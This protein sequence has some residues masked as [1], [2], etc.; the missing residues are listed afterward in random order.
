MNESVVAAR[1]QMT[2]AESVEQANERMLASMRKVGAEQQ[3]YARAASDGV[4]RLAQQQRAAAASADRLAATNQRVA[5]SFAGMLAT[6]TGVGG[7]FL[8]LAQ[9]AEQ[10]QPALEALEAKFT[11]VNSVGTRFTS[12]AG[13]MAAAMQHLPN[14][15]MGMAVGAAVGQGIAALADSMNKLNGEVERLRELDAKGKQISYQKR[16]ESAGFMGP[17]N[18]I[19]NALGDWEEVDNTGTGVTTGMDRMLAKLAEWGDTAATVSEAEKK[20]NAILVQNKAVV[21]TYTTSIDQHERSL[22]QRTR[23]VLESVDAMSKDGEAT[24]M[25]KERIA[26]LLPVLQ[27]LAKEHGENIPEG[28]AN[29]IAKTTAAAK[30]VGLLESEFETVGK[31]AKKHKASIEAFVENLLLLKTSDVLTAD[32]KESLAGSFEA[33]SEAAKELGITISADLIG[34]MEQLTDGVG[35]FSWGFDWKKQGDEIHAQWLANQK[36]QQENW[37]KWDQEFKD[38]Q[39]ASADEVATEM[40]KRYG[41]AGKN[42]AVVWSTHFG[43]MQAELFGSMQPLWKAAAE[44]VFGGSRPIGGEKSG[45]QNFLSG[46]GLGGEEDEGPTL[47][48]KLAQ[49]GQH[50]RQKMGE[51]QMMERYFDENKGFNKHHLDK[52]GEEIKDLDLAERRARG[53]RDR[54]SDGLRERWGSKTETEVRTYADRALDRIA[55]TLEKQGG[56]LDGVEKA[57]RAMGSTADRQ[58]KA[59]EKSN[60]LMEE[61]VRVQTDSQ[62]VA[63][64]AIVAGRLGNANATMGSRSYGNTGRGIGG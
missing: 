36:K 41:E 8:V 13:K 47:S 63:E 60:G 34:K 54:I 39:K 2:G 3:R 14:L 25:S 31:A 23:A 24:K 16:D 40:E 43:K 49:L 35:K 20:L 29:L 50:K 12:T 57:T 55:T 30:A 6:S 4:G 61:S 32:G 10:M 15:F 56:K 21:D 42:I 22:F 7:Q 33:A 26:A 62:R 45:A 44:S 17:I 27:D 53:Q 59:L 58:L 11:T 1:V 5:K 19:R 37:K 51:L 38:L 64:K 28:L 52:R 9:R 46:L 48:Q 18:K